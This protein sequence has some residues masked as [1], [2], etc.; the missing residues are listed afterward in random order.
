[1]LWSSLIVLGTFLRGPNWN[2]F[3]P[4]EYWDIHKLEALTN[5]NLSEYIWVRRCGQ[6]LADALVHPRDFGILLVLFYVF[7]LPSLLA[8]TS[9]KRYY[10]KMGAPRYY[11]GVVPVPDDDVAA[12]QDAAA[13]AV[14][15]EVHR[16]DSR[17]SS[18]TSEPMAEKKGVG[19]AYNVDFLNVV[20]AAS[21]LFLFLS[22]VWMVWDDFD[23]EWKNT[24]R[25]F[26][27]LRVQVTQAQLAAGVAGRRQEQAAAAPGAARGGAEERR[28]EPG[29]G[30]RAAGKLNEVDNRLYR[31]TQRL[32]VRKGQLRSGPVRLR[33]ARA[34]RRRAAS[35]EG[36]NV[37]EAG[38]ALNELNLAAR[39]GDAEKRGRPERARAV[40]RRGR[41]RSQKQ[42]DEITPSR[43]RLQ[44]AAR[45]HRARA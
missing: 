26:T 43:T 39:E 9:F 29:E 21:S 15:P 25:Q 38:E 42:I 19:H 2:F 6:R 3:G 7:A 18:S 10:E 1:M 14:Q 17:N 5:V 35:R 40:H 30:R 13:V 12:D 11:V 33:S 16:G 4:Y 28:G 31:A 37:A 36:Q 20:F 41:R 34:A 22:V 27:Q 32:P 23:R 8:K 44:Q 45:R 24:Q